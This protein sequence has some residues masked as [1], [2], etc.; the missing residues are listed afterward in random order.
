MGLGVGCYFFHKKALVFEEEQTSLIRCNFPHPLHLKVCSRA[1][2]SLRVL[3]FLFFSNAPLP[4]VVAHGH[5]VI[6]CI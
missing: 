3:Q 1:V 4:P 5:V 2:T 6:D